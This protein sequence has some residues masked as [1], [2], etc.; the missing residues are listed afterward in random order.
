MEHRKVSNTIWELEN[1]KGS[2]MRY[3]K[4]LIDAM[5][6]C[7]EYLFKELEDSHIGEQF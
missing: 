3:F 6:S 5:D 1:P 4:E 7:V 2:N